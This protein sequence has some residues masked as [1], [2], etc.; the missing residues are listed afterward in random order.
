MFQ[1]MAWSAIERVS[2]QAVQ[3][4][5]GII[6]ARI[7]TPKEYGIIGIL[8]VFIAISNVFIDSGFTKALIQKQERTEKD[9][10]TVFWFNIII[11]LIC[12]G[13]LWLA[14]PFVADFYGIELLSILL[15][16]LAISLI[17]NAL[18]A[19]PTTLLTIKLDFKT[20][21]K[22]NLI[23]TIISGGI[24]IY[25]AYTG[26]G[27]W[28]LVAQTLAR[29]IFTAILMWFWIQ[30]KPNW[31]FSKTS[32]KGLF[33]YGSNLLAS[34]LLNVTV[35]NFYAL[36]I[37]KLIST[38]DLGYYTRGTQFSDVVYG[39]V[40]SV[41][42]NVLLPGLST[43]QDQREILINH[44]RNIIKATAVLV[45]PL[46]LFLSVIAEPL[47]R[48]LLTEKWILAVPI[49]QIFCVAR[50]IT[51]ISGINVNLLYVI[52]R[53]DL[54]LKQQYV[55]IGVRVVFLIAAL[56]FGIIYIAIAELLSTV[57][58]FFINT[59]YPGKIM[60]YGAFA[61]LK[62]LMMIIVAGL[63]MALIVFGTTYFIENDILKL[64]IAPIVAIL[65]YFGLV[66]LFKI[67]ELSSII[68]KS[69]EFLK[70]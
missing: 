18:L 49:M 31:V 53:T 3:F 4:V 42:D 57:L 13:V 56:K 44:T 47:I 59:Y 32:L 66:H 19:V 21:T 41:L 23:S 39:V 65:S 16:V 54:T 29:S 55:K 48:V 9:K 33:S 11:S 8:I 15:R 25:M 17:I 50:L 63:L 70:K 35:N 45:V 36:F 12:Y 34:S 28:A 20:I 51:L 2:V 43:I 61:Q 60:K 40:G 52:G 10:S 6:L 69:R 22:I 24:A 26:F 58:H 46:F 64:C 37:A 38:E 30:W 1:G 67:Q 5:L 14:A 27:V 62:D 68:S 7:L